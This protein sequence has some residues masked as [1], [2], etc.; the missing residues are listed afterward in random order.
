MTR[1]EEYLLLPT[2]I[3]TND[4]GEA[5]CTALKE[6]VSRLSFWVLQI[7]GALDLEENPDKVNFPNPQT[8]REIAKLSREIEALQ[9]KCQEC[10]SKDPDPSRISTLEKGV[11]TLKQGLKVTMDRLDQFLSY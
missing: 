8:C 7:T 1:R 11:N 9:E 4:K 3:L 6:T 10:H 5:D 2:P